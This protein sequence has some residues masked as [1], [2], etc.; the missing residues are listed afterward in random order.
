MPNPQKQPMVKTFNTWWE[1]Q[2]EGFN[3]L[4][5]K[6]VPATVVSVEANCAIVTVKVEIKGFIFPQ[7]RCPV[8]SPQWDR[9][10]IQEGDK[11]VLLSADF[12]MGGMSGIGGGTA[13]MIQMAN[14][15]NGI[16]FPIGNTAFPEA[17]DS[18]PKGARVI[19][20]PDGTI[21]TNKDS[22]DVG[23]EAQ[24]FN[25]VTVKVDGKGN[26]IIYGAKSVSTDVQGY[27]SRTTYVGGNQWKIDIYD[28]GA[29]VS[30]VHHPVSPPQIS[31]P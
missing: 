26:V 29:S 17:T 5:S 24:T 25:G 22:I 23:S 13:E 16:W 30:T 27:G 31:A 18:F 2:A 1:R 7:V 11:G 3:D 12:Y 28:L 19:Y 21:L 8:G 10:P 20:G 6:S 9:L 15:A 4:L 14:L